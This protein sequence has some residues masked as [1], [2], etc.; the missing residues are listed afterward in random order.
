MKFFEALAKKNQMKQITFWDLKIEYVW[1]VV[2]KDQ[3]DYSR[4]YTEYKKNNKVFFDDSAIQFSSNGL[5]KLM[6]FKMNRDF[7]I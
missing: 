4:Y 1:M 7:Y 3:N 5:Y 2:P 6:T